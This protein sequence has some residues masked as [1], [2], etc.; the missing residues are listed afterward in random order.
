[1]IT[2]YEME[3]NDEIIAK[4]EQRLILKILPFLPLILAWS[5]FK[6]IK[7]IIN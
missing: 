7:K 6:K 2:A 4:D 3:K 5:L 1:M